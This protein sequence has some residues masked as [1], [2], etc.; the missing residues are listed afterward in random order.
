MSVPGREQRRRNRQMLRDGVA[1]H[2]DLL[3][4]E[5]AHR[6]DFA[7][8]EALGE[9][10]DERQEPRARASRWSILLTAAMAGRPDLAMRSSTMLIPARPFE[11]RD[12]EDAQIRL[13][14]RRPGGA[15]HGAI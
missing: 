11:R 3:F 12:D 15:I 9:L 2:I 4:L 14:E 7:K 8:R 6:H 5:R 10:G 1:Q 13:R